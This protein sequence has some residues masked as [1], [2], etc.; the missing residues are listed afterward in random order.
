MIH[1]YAF[2]VLIQSNISYI[3][4]SGLIDLLF[5]QKMGMKLI[6]A[7]NLTT[8]K[9][10]KVYYQNL[11]TRIQTFAGDGSGHCAIFFTVLRNFYLVNLHMYI[12]VYV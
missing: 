5:M 4:S 6:K 10:V 1:Y 12:S 3:F 7:L 11:K 8:H 2:F 9:I